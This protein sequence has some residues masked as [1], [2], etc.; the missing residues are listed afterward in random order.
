MLSDRFR[1]LLNQDWHPRSLKDLVGFL[2]MLDD[3][4]PPAEASR[5]YDMAGHSLAAAREQEKN[6][7]R[8]QILA[9]LL[10]D[11]STFPDHDRYSSL[12]DRMTP[13]EAAKVCDQVARLVLEDLSE[14]KVSDLYS[15]DSDLYSWTFSGRSEDAGFPRWSLSS[16]VATLVERMGPGE[17]EKVASPAA[18]VLA[19][20]VE[21][22]TDAQVRRAIALDLTRVTSRLSPAEAAEVCGRVARVLTAALER[23]THEKDRLIL[24]SG[25]K[26]FS[27]RLASSDATSALRLVARTAARHEPNDLSDLYD[28]LGQKPTPADASRAAW[29]IMAAL[30]QEK[31]PN[32]RW[33]LAAGLA[34]LAVRMEPAEV[35]RISGHTLPQLVTAMQQKGDVGETFSNALKVVAGRDPSRAAQAARV[36]TAELRKP[37]MDGSHRH[38]LL[39]CLTALADHITADEAAE[40]AQ[41]LTATLIRKPEDSGRHLL[42]GP[43]AKFASRMT[44]ADAAKSSQVLADA[45][46]EE[47][48]WDIRKALVKSLISLASRMTPTEAATV[49]GRVARMLIVPGNLIRIGR[50]LSPKKER[51]S[52][53]SDLVSLAGPMEPAEANRIGREAIRSILRELQAPDNSIVPLL[54]QLDPAT[55]RRWLGKW[56]FGSVRITS[57]ALMT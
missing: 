29:L 4:M 33:C 28:F 12:I 41:M 2:D 31:D 30:E 25:L 14:E 52:L 37:D 50:M 21:K 24:A 13:T 51:W 45:L 26:Y 17:A 27:V 15:K 10:T 57:C 53:A 32:T 11:A 1:R 47:K 42:L 8:R 20:A 6:A 3:Y 5:L 46:V 49:R 16:A 44:P 19:D 18:R 35:A 23:E 38:Q 40:L 36:L 55:A 54:T 7:T 39:E 22:T 56:L 43:L 48:D 9:H 34:W